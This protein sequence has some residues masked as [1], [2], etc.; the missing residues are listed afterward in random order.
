MTKLVHAC[1][2]SRFSRVQLF[3]TIWTVTCQALLSMGFSRQEYWSGLSFP[4]PGDLPDPARSNPHLLQL[5]RWQADSL[6]LGHLGLKIT[7]LLNLGFPC[8]SAGKG[9]ACNLEDLGSIPGLGCNTG[10]VGSIPGSG[11]SPGGGNSNPLRYSYLES[12][13]ARGGW[14]AT[15]HM[16]TKSPKRLSV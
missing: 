9:S 2:L 3:A 7:L 13:M 14:W 10:D 6:P 5:L 1:V 8:H 15:V 12:P 4:P 11:R 16:I